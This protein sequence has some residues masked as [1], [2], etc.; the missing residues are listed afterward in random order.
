VAAG[1]HPRRR[2]RRAGRSTPTVPP[3][4][5]LRAASRT[6]STRRCGN[7]DWRG[8]QSAAIRVCRRARPTVVASTWRPTSASTTTSRSGSRQAH[9][10][11]LLLL[12]TEPARC[13]I[14]TA[15]SSARSPPGPPRSATSPSSGSRRRPP[16]GRY[17]TSRARDCQARSIRSCSSTCAVRPRPPPGVTYLNT[18]VDA[19]R[20]HTASPSLKGAL[21]RRACPGQRGIG[22]CATQAWYDFRR[23]VGSSCS[24]QAI[25][26]ASCTR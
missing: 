1:K 24:R 14:S 7:G 6:R 3:R 13:S 20:A 10:P 4:A 15:S 8:K 22:A 2:A 11:P 23:L 17:G 12:P 21:R 18:A 9:R 25:P 26:L 16:L 5:S 19:T